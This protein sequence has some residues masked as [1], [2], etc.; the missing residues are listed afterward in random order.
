MINNIKDV[1]SYKNSYNEKREELIN[2]VNLEKIKKQK[3]GKFLFLTF[4][5]FGIYGIYYL[6]K[7]TE[8][9][10]ELCKG[11]KKRSPNYIIVFLLGIL[12]FGIYKIYWWYRQAE[13]IYQ[14]GKDLGVHLPDDSLA[15]L[16]L[17][18]F[19]PGLG[20]FSSVYMVFDNLNRLIEIYE[21]NKSKSEIEDI[22]KHT[23]LVIITCILDFILVIIAISAFF[24][25]GLDYL[26]T[27]DKNI[28]AFIG[29]DKMIEETKVD[30]DYNYAYEFDE[31][32][33]MHITLTIKNNTGLN[34]K[35]IEV[36][37]DEDGDWNHD[38]IDNGTILDSQMKITVPLD[39]S[40]ESAYLDFAFIDSLNKIY[41]VRNLN[42][43]GVRG[44]NP[45][46]ILTM[47][48][49]EL[50]GTLSKDKTI[51]KTKEKKAVKGTNIEKE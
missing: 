15:V 14:R 31:N 6:Y 11:D 5:T 27:N 20:T 2:S 41:T 33:K 34:L 28:E 7:F 22:P 26:I 35:N 3:F 9:I 23:P 32:G 24:I 8:E 18:I 50:K 21:G 51:K 29:N 30:E 10:N 47:D 44:N 42:F 13:R 4:I 48:D 19:A 1:D 46:L 16:L 38:I 40:E 39:I 37:N 43:S 12:T 49:G 17:M 25:G 45:K 36:K